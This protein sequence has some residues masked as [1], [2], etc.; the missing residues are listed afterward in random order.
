MIYTDLPS[1]QTLYQVMCKILCDCL[2]TVVFHVCYIRM[3]NK[4]AHTCY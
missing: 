4:H 3:P 2:D 1:K